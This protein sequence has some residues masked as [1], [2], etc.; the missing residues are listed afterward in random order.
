L[1]VVFVAQQAA[2]GKPPRDQAALGVVNEGLPVST[3]EQAMLE[4]DQA[5]GR[6]VV[7]AA[8]LHRMLDGGRMPALPAD[9]ARLPLFA[10]R[11]QDLDRP[12]RRVATQ[13]PA[14]AVRPCDADEPIERVVLVA[15]ETGPRV[16]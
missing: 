12:A 14:R 7:G 16:L 11:P 10:T 3:P 15:D 5:T 1:G 8:R 13:A 2:V 6:I 4:A 9:P